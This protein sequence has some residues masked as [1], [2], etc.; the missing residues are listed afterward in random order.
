MTNEIKISEDLF[1]QLMRAV[2]MYS[3]KGDIIKIERLID[4][5]RLSNYKYEASK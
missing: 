4:Q 1:N 2:Y 5:Q 3:P